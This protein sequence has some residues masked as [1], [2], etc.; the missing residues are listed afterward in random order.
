MRCLFEALVDGGNFDEAASNGLGLLWCE[1]HSVDLRCADAK[2]SVRVWGLQK[3]D[4]YWCG[5]V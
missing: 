4:A 2:G 3:H 1:K 5:M